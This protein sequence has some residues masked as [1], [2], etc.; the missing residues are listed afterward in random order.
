MSDETT[1]PFGAVSPNCAGPTQ[2]DEVMNAPGGDDDVRVVG[3]GVDGCYLSA[4][5]PHKQLWLLIQELHT[6]VQTQKQ[7]AQQMQVLFHVEKDRRPEQT[8]MLVDA[9]GNETGWFLNVKML[10]DFVGYVANPM[11]CHRMHAAK[12]VVSFFFVQDALMLHR[13]AGE[14]LIGHDLNQVDWGR[15][16]FLEET[17]GVLLGPSLTVRTYSEREDWLKQL[18]LLALVAQVEEMEA[19]FPVWSE[20]IQGDNAGSSAPAGRL[21]LFDSFVTAKWQ[22]AAPALFPDQKALRQIEQLVLLWQ[23]K[24]L[25]QMYLRP[26]IARDGRSTMQS[27]D[28]ED[29]QSLVRLLQD[30]E[31]RLVRLE[32][33]VELQ[34]AE[35]VFPRRQEA[36]T[37]TTRCGQTAL[38]DAS[39]LAR[40]E[41]DERTGHISTM[42]NFPWPPRRVTVN[43]VSISHAWESMEHPDPW[44]FQLEAIVDAFRVRLCDGLV[45]VFFDYISLHQYKRSTAQDQLFQRALHD[46]HILY[47]HEAVEV[48][49]LEDLTPESLKGSRKGAIPVYCEGKDTVKA[50]PIQDLKLN[51][52]PYD[53]P[54]RDGMGTPESFGEGSFDAVVQLQEK[55]FEQKASST[56]HLLIQDLDA[57][58]I[59]TLCAAMPF[60]R[61]LKEVVI[62]AAS[63]KVRCSLA[64]A[65]VRSG[66]CDIQMNCEHLRDEDAIAF[67]VA[68]SKNDCGH[69]QRLS[70]KCNAISKRGTDALQQMAAQ[71]EAQFVVQRFTSGLRCRAR[72]L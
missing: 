23:G 19:L 67:A 44:R 50:V 24:R 4:E 60:Y 55:V 54:G 25:Q 6:I 66:A 16:E 70:I 9:R 53:V 32:Y 64:A 49:L 5:L 35:S 52:T 69:L 13:R 31:I 68:L 22:W 26:A 29:S 7:M 34:K 59:K 37:E 40:L 20:F 46:M 30:A 12:G 14:V 10:E 38:V 11:L 8:L 36:E 61:N 41:I 48:H 62:P 17:S 33:L 56:E 65:V 27:Y 1:V 28:L 43:L 15:A 45:W 72:G 18:R 42:I 63:L 39:E 21:N 2:D 71:Q 57:V 3:E 51:V 47:A 58:K